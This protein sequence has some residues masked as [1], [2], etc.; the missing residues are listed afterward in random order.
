LT[1]GAAILDYQ[2]S[3]GGPSEVEFTTLSCL[4]RPA[5]HRPTVTGTIG[6]L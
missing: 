6:R 2:T 3:K 1:Y 4:L 5:G